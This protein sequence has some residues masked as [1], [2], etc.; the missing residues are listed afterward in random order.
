LQAELGIS[1]P[2]DIHK[3]EVD[4]VSEHVMQIPEPQVSKN[5][6][7]SGQAHETLIQHRCR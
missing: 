6:V 7:A 3:Q 4:R 1:H 5:T 2:G